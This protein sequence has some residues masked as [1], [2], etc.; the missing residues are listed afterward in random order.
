MLSAFVHNTY[1]MKQ[2]ERPTCQQLLEHHVFVGVSF[3]LI[4]QYT[5][6]PAAAPLPLAGIG[7]DVPITVVVHHS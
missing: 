7:E 1:V 2:E 4:S 3:N 5:P 6:P